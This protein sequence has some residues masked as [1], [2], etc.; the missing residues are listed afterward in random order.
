VQLP[1]NDVLLM[2]VMMM[3]S[4][5][6]ILYI[7]YKQED[8][9]IFTDDM[10]CHTDKPVKE[11]VTSFGQED[12]L[13]LGMHESQILEIKQGKMPQSLFECPFFSLELQEFSDNISALRLGCD[14]KKDWYALMEDE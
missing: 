14:I 11:V 8:D 2:L 4:S 7:I 5:W 3:Y 10:K 6:H 13:M 1:Q 9:I 12:G